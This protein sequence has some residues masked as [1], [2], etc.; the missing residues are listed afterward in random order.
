MSCGS[1][2]GR[3][4]P[5][6]GNQ[7]SAVEWSSADA[8]V[9]HLALPRTGPPWRDVPD[10]FGAWRSVWEWHRRRSDDGAYVRGFAAVREAA[11]ERDE[12]V[13]TLLALPPT[14]T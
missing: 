5:A 14:Q 7:G 12:Q 3:V 8:E 2:S 4:L 6:G 1:W 11:P 9:D 13:R 10:N